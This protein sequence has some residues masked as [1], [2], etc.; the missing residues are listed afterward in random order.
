MKISNGL[1]LLA[2]MLLPMELMADNT[3]S[4]AFALEK[5]DRI[6]ISGAGELLLTQGDAEALTITTSEKMMPNVEIH[7]RNNTLYLRTTSSGWELFKWWDNWGETHHVVFAVTTKQLRALQV[8]GAS[9]VKGTDWSSDSLAMDITGAGK[10]QFGRLTVRDLKVSLTGA[11]HLDI[12]QLNGEKISA[13]LTGAS[14]VFIQRPGEVDTQRIQLTG[15]SHY[16][17]AP[18]KSRQADIELSGASNAL[19]YATEHL[20]VG[21]SGASNVNY[22]GDAKTATNVSGVSNVNHLGSAPTR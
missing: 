14:K 5:I 17:A 4:R 1:F 22:Y 18:L 15:A 12:A 9:T 11:S 13:D 6:E 16:Q 7:Q 2:I 20:K 8:T 21:A 10:I 19:V 3:I